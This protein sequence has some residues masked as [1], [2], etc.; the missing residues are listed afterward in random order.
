MTERSRVGK[1]LL[2][3][4]AYGFAIGAVH[5]WRYAAHNLVKFPLLLVVTALVARGFT[6]RP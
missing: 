4:A 3:S 2:A 5:S 1:A 6:P